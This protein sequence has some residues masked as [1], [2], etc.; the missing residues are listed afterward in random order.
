MRVFCR[1]L[2]P[3]FLCVKLVIISLAIIR[4]HF[5]AH[6]DQRRGAVG[7]P[8]ERERD[9]AAENDN[10]VVIYAICE[11]IMTANHTA[12]VFIKVWTVCSL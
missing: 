8:A 12:P 11:L 5:C 6:R 3:P 9:G 1:I 2:I 7:L 4:W 10:H